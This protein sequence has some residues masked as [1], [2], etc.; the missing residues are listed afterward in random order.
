MQANLE[1]L[2]KQ[3]IGKRIAANTGLMVGA[4]FLSVLM[5]FCTLMIATRALSNEAF[6][7][8]VFLHAYMLFFSEVATFQNWQAI[9]RFGAEDQKAN[10]SEGLA[11]LIKLG[12]KLDAISALLA[13]LGSLALF[14]IVMLIIEMFPSIGPD[15]GTSAAELQKYA[16]VYCL[17]VLA[18]QTSTSV[19]VLRLFDR[20][21]ILALEAM[22]MPALRFIGSLYAFYAGWGVEGFLCVWFFAS[23]ANYIALILTGGLELR[24]RKMLGRVLRAKSTFRN[25]RE[26]LWPFFIKSNIDSTLAAG[27]LHLPLL[28]VT[29][30]FG[31][32]L[33]AIY[34]IAEEV[35]RLLSEGFKLLDQ[36]IYPELSKMVVNGEADKIWRLV[37]RAAF[38][39]LSVGFAMSA[40][41]WVWG[42]DILSAVATKDYSASA[43]Y[44]SLLV[45]A[46]ALTGLVAPLFPIFYAAGK[47]ERAI[48]AR[49]ATLIAY[50]GA[51]I[52]L[53]LMIGEMGPGW[54]V[55]VGNIV[56]V[57]L[58]FFMAKKTLTK[59]VEHT[60][61]T[62]LPEGLRTVAL[63]GQSDKR[64][65]GMPIAKWQGRAMKKAGGHV[66][67][68][69]VRSENDAK[70]YL[71][72]TWV[73]SAA[74]AKGFISAPKTALI[75]DNIIAGVTDVPRDIAQRLI[76]DNANAALAA[77]M[78]LKAPDELADSY[79]KTLRKTDPPYGIDV[80]TAP[81]EPVMRRQFASSY[82]GITDFVTKYFWPL[83]AYYVTRLCARL[84]LT[85]NMVTTIG[86]V[87]CIA[88]FYFFM[89]G[90]WALG[91]LTGWL[92]TF[93][94]TVDGKLART[95]MTY[96]SWG[97]AYDHG[98]DL[99][100]PPF[101]YWA[102]FAGLGG[103]IAWS[104]PASWLSLPMNLALMAIFL[105]YLVDRII[106]GIFIV[107]HGFHIHVW[108]PFNSLLRIYTARRNPNTFI[109]MIAC[110]LSLLI[111]DAAQWGF[112]AVAIW[113]WTCILINIGVVIV[114]AL[115]RKPVTSWMDD[116]I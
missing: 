82:K 69:Q 70:V 23:L 45:P 42:P 20:F 58:V 35:S 48:I 16:A 74:L 99:I 83:P 21:Q 52:V 77:G 25:Q 4:K 5:G 41:V 33:A 47:P 67:T 113:T 72:V 112:Y 36:V 64:I 60:C 3:T 55:I 73:L 22:I 75:I 59:T 7:I 101:W 65:W 51:F 71:G 15:S 111:K 37:M 66:C 108:R 12:V 39:L 63:V 53:S 68:D 11:K 90:Q 28:L 49:G 30:F 61:E 91:F 56:G 43:P 105:G 95:T 50:I 85:P 100:H 10:D 92:M 87:L 29:A 76:G 104:D 46:A 78:T 24:R 80:S 94:D 96:S 9:I 19:G 110:I 26:G 114:A 6:G 103:T 31:P 81:I 79:N 2:S 27:T 102:W 57:G 54:A 38:A 93:L 97:N 40:M 84:R 62:G 109:F 86:L 17:V 32:V 89:Q 107:Q 115:S 14:G 106:E 18:R 98:I 34:K 44:A 13:Y 8:V 116:T 1:T 88:A